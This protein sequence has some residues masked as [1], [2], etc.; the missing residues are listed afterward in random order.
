VEPVVRHTVFR[1]D[2]PHK[3]GLVAHPQDWVDFLAL[4]PR[5]LRHRLDRLGIFV[6]RAVVGLILIVGPRRVLIQADLLVG[7]L[8]DLG[9]DLGEALVV[10]GLFA[11]PEVFVVLIVPKSFVIAHAGGVARAVWYYMWSKGRFNLW[12]TPC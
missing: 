8:I 5:L 11:D 12:G 1:L 7:V 3:A 6:A 4:G 2:D 9:L 10:H